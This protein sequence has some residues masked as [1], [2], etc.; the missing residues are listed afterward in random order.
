MKVKNRKNPVIMTLI[1][2]VGL[3]IVIL[4][5]LSIKSEATKKSWKNFIMKP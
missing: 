3:L 4:I 5:G 2:V 1:V